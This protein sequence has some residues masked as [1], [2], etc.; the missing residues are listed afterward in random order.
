VRT[1]GCGRGVGGE[2]GSRQMNLG[3]W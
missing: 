2:R 1:P 3:D